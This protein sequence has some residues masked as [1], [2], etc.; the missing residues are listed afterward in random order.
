[1]REYLM[2]CRLGRRPEPIVLRVAGIGMG[3]DGT[4]ECSFRCLWR[5]EERRFTQSLRW[6]DPLFLR[7]DRTAAL[8]LITFDGRARVVAA[9]LEPLQ[10]AERE[11]Q[12]I[13]DAAEAE[14]RQHPVKVTEPS[15]RSVTAPSRGLRSAGPPSD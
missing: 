12:R 6:G 1:M 13:L 8:G 15:P 10:M 3:A 4:S 11:R 9:T 2:W 7:A 5:G 14:R